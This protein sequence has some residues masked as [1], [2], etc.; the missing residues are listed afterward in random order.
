MHAINDELSKWRR[1]K[2]PCINIIK[3][4][5]VCVC[6][7]HCCFRRFDAAL[8]AGDT[9]QT[10]M[11]ARYVWDLQGL[12]PKASH[13]QQHRR[14]FDTTDEVGFKNR[15]AGET[16]WRAWTDF[17]KMSCFCCCVCACGEED[18]R[19][20]WCNCRLAVLQVSKCRGVAVATW[21]GIDC[22]RV[23]EARV[24]VAI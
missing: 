10:H 23:D 5:C 8:H 24:G 3:L 17:L 12:R 16:G 7:C 22:H 1:T 20:K 15:V 4:V 11:A 2:F 19:T 9:T 13:H 14:V 6:M 18:R 21:R